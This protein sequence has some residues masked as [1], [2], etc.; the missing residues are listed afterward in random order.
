[1]KTAISLAERGLGQTWPNPSVGCVIVAENK[2]VGRGWTQPGG[3]PHAETDALKRAGEAAQGATAYVTLEPC[4][5]HGET[6]PCAQ[7][8]IDSGM[9]RVVVALE[10][11]DPRVSGGGVQ[12]LRDAGIRVDLGV[13]QAQAEVVTSGFLKRVTKSRPHVT[14][15]LATTLDG[16]IATRSGDSEWVTGDSARRSGHMLRANH[17]AILVGARTAA[18]DNPILTCRLPGL[19]SRSPVRIV[20]DGRMRLPLTHELVTSAR[21]TP[22]WLFAFAETPQNADRRR[23]YIDGAVEIFDISPNPDGYP[24]L[25]AVLA[26]LADKG[27]TRLLVEGG[28]VIAAAFLK[29]GLIDEVFWYRAAKITGGDGLPAIAEMGIERLRDAKCIN[30]LYVESV[31]DDVVERYSVTG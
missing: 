1:M 31:G 16:R 25:E 8:L 29:L 21:E 9:S 14:L 11:P 12:M 7:A 2:V 13:C 17:D 27:I 23:A 26:V 20:V 22:T 18:E 15:K 30:R 24:D 10:D 4:A 5:H 19:A 3:R 6:P 28:G